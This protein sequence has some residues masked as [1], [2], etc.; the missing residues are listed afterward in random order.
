MLSRRVSRS[1]WKFLLSSAMSLATCSLGLVVTSA[2]ACADLGSGGR[3]VVVASGLSQMASGG[4][5]GICV[6]SS[7]N[8]FF[9][10]T[11]QN[12]IYELTAAS[13]YTRVITVAGSGQS[14]NL[15]AG[16]ATSSPMT[17]PRGLACRPDSSIFFTTAGQVGRL[18][19]RCRD[20]DP[21][22]PQNPWSQAWGL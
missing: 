2:P 3:L 9:A 20:R 4:M 15:V 6:D 7:D 13:V 1:R 12:K 11:P 8:L 18:I 21:G 5:R 22:G 16:A 10:N 14:G 19:P 17:N